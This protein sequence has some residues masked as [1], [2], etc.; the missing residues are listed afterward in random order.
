M[1]LQRGQLL[2]G[3]PALRAR[4]GLLVGVVEHVLVEGLLEGEGAPADLALVGGLAYVRQIIEFQDKFRLPS[5]FKHS[6]V[7]S[8]LCFFRKYFVV[9]VLWHTSHSHC[10]PPPPPFP[11]LL[12]GLPTELLLFF[13]WELVMCWESC[14]CLGKQRP[15]VAHLN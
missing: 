7:C 5:T 11:E 10:F 6:P 3:P 9:N 8:L 4:V 14:C 2:E 15:Q 12:F 13:T 1:Y